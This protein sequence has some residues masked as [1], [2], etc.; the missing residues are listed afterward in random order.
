MMGKLAHAGGFWCESYRGML[1]VGPTGNNVTYYAVMQ[2]LDCLFQW[3][4]VTAH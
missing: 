3:Y 1:T 4:V 2:F